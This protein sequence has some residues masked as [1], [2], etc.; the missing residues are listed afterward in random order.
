MNAPDEDGHPKNREHDCQHYGAQHEPGPV[1]AGWWGPLILFVH[2]VGNISFKDGRGK[3]IVERLRT[4]RF[5][6][7]FKQI[8]TS[9]P[10]ANNAESAQISELLWPSPKFL[11]FL[12][13]QNGPSMSR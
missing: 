9:P 13:D 7:G 11:L 3:E 5:L 8:H 2:T 6:Q 10:F 1:V 12:I 4:L